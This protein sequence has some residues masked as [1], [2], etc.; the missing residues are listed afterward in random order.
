M[1]P[2]SQRQRYLSRRDIPYLVTASML[3]LTSPSSPG[4]SIAE[5]GCA[6]KCNNAEIATNLAESAVSKEE[7]IFVF[8]CEAP[9]IF[10]GTT[11][12]EIVKEAKELVATSASRGFS[13]RPQLVLR[14]GREPGRKYGFSS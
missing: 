7:G 6:T 12:Q 8:R 5:Q 13:L 1:S 11:M 10:V 3:R 4:S 14:S 9:L 2:D